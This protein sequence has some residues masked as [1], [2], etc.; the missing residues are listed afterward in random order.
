MKIMEIYGIFGFILFENY[1][2]EYLKQCYTLFGR[3]LTPDWTNK[4]SIQ[5]K[6]SEI[7]LLL[8]WSS[9]LREEMS[10]QYG[11]NSCILSF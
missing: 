4:T 1:F 10:C 8:K 6:M 9:V 2:E 7:Y 5:N 11:K 3:I